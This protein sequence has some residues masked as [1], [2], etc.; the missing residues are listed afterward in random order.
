M[1]RESHAFWRYSLRV[2]RLPAVQAACLALQEQ[3]AADVNLVLLC[4]WLAQQGRAL[5]KRTLRRAI[6]AV[7]RWQREVVAPVRRARRALKTTTGALPAAW[8]TGLRSRLGRIELDLEYVEQ[9]LL[10]DFAASL[11][12]VA[13]APPSRAAAQAS[14]A[15][16]V[17]LLSAAPHRLAAPQLARLLD[18]CFG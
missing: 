13:R 7:E 2:Y 5:D 18:A 9:R 10:A 3:C 8:A 12:P 15:R 16:Y 14:L 11:P 6:T 1:R 4:C 17:D